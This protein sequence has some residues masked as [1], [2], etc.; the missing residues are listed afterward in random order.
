MYFQFYPLN[1]VNIV[2]GQ[3][4]AG[5]SRRGHQLAIR[6][7]GFKNEQEHT[8]LSTY[9]KGFVINVM[10]FLPVRG[11]DQGHLCLE[12]GGWVHGAVCDQ[13]CNF[14]I[15]VVFDFNSSVFFLSHGYECMNC[16]AVS[17]ST[18]MRQ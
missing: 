16:H 18:N 15:R 10:R 2:N 14:E 6:T 12:C 11:R 3:A 5:V 17:D 13:D 4:E 9:D 1:D 8:P 7:L